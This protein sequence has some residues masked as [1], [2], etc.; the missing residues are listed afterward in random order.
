MGG[1]SCL[2]PAADWA[3]TAPTQSMKPH[4]QVKATDIS[5]SL[6]E[7]IGPG[8]NLVWCATFQLA[9]NE[10]TRLT[11]GPLRLEPELPLARELNQQ[12]FTRAW[13]D[14]ANC[15]A[16]ADLVGNGVY[17]RI[18]SA[19]RDITTPADYRRYR[20][21]RSLAVRPQDLVAYAYLQADLKF[22]SPFEDLGDKLAFQGTNV[23]AFGIGE[24]YKPAH[25][26]L[27]PQVWVHDFVSRDDFV[28][29]LTSRVKGD[30]LI[31]AKMRPKETLLATVRQVE[32]RLV[33]VHTSPR[34]SS[35]PE[36]EGEATQEH[37]AGRGD[38][39]MVPKTAFDLGRKYEEL[40]GCRLRPANPKLAQDLVLVDAEQQ[41]L[42]EMN[43]K[44]V[45][46]RSQAQIS[47]GC[48]A[49][50]SPLPKRWMVFDGPFL[51]LLQRE[52]APL[53]YL[54]IWVANV[55]LLQQLAPSSQTG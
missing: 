4:E 35:T 51:L 30:R 44:G 13:V 9:W 40:R 20:P 28:V 43:E 33:R 1:L 16:I 50:M 55:E 14:P 42:F 27:Y 38:V 52:G 17:G 32:R 53:P 24:A 45:K 47:F 37:L 11:G 46:L 49:P 41:V 54:A 22:P 8:R 34:N 15:V 18:E 6:N 12:E 3:T 10:C 2:G 36:G 39:L 29:E 7:K 23:S 19:L 21:S 25:D 31:L 48:S 26:K 5:A